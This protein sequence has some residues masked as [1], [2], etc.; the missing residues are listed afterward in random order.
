MKRWLIGEPVVL[1]E[2]TIAR[3][4]FR[5]IGRP[6]DADRDRDVFGSEFLGQTMVFSIVVPGRTLSV[7]VIP[8]VLLQRLNSQ[9][10]GWTTPKSIIPLSSDSR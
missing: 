5:Q 10:P 9:S 2:A 8:Q 6:I 4:L 7:P 3:P 1:N